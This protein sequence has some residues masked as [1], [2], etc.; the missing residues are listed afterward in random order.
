[1]PVREIVGK[2]FAFFLVGAALIGG[3]ALAFYG[4]HPYNDYFNAILA[5]FLVVS[6]VGVWGFGALTIV[7]ILAEARKA[8]REHDVHV[9]P[10]PGPLGPPPPWGMGDIGRPGHGIKEVGGAAAR[11]GGGPRLMSVSVSSLDAPILVAVLL[12]W[13]LGMLI[14]L[15][16]R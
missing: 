12:V 14:W 1:M 9:T 16:P 5:G 15:A 10:R 13:T 3:G 2:S 7:A 4:P 11:G 8:A 6:G